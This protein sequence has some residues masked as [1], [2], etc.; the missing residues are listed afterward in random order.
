VEIEFKEDTDKEI[1]EALAKQR[2]SPIKLIKAFTVSTEWDSWL[3]EAG[4]V[5]KDDRG[6][7]I[8]ALKTLQGICT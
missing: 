6:A 4:I 5:R 8:L 2:L 7:I 3:S 1:F